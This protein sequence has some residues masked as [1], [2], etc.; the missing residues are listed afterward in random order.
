MINKMSRFT[1]VG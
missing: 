1:N